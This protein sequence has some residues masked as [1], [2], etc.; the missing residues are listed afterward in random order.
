MSALIM[1][2]RCSSND[3]HAA[4]D[5]HALMAD[6]SVSAPPRR[7][8]RPPVAPPRSSRPLACDGRSS[9]SRPRSGRP[10][11]RAAGSANRCRTRDARPPRAGCARASRAPRVPGPRSAPRPRSRS[12]RR[13]RGL[14]RRD[15]PERVEAGHVVGDRP[16]HAL[17][18]MAPC[19]RDARA[20]SRRRPR[21]RR[22]RGGR[23]DR[24]S[25]SRRSAS[26]GCRASRPV[27]VRSGPT[28]SSARQR[29]RARRTA[30]ASPPSA[31]RPSRRA[32]RREAGLQQRIVRIS[33]REGVEREQILRQRWPGDGNAG[34]DAD[35]QVARAPGVVVEIEIRRR[36]CDSCT[37]VT[38]CSC[39]SRIARRSAR[40][41]SSA[42]AAAWRARRARRP[43]PSGGRSARRCAR[44]GR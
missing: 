10:A 19:L 16:L 7:G 21:T 31:T 38:P 30:R 41:R 34:V 25:P 27:F 42:S 11:D 44:R 9:G 32:S 36:A 6:F 23:R 18:A 33:L 12:G 22:A 17:D 29:R 40:A 5:V 15:D 13:V 43:H 35:G 28:A 8:P 37:L 20:R 14:Q 39:A 1:P 26:R 2:L 4:P 3:A 24:H